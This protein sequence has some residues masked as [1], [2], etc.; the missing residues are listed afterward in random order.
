MFAE[1]VGLVRG[2]AVEHL[3]RSRK[4]ALALVGQCGVALVLGQQCAVEHRGQYRPLDFGHSPEA[5]LPSTRLVF[6]PLGVEGVGAVFLREIEVDRH[7]LPQDDPVV[8]DGRDVPVRV[9]LEVV[10]GAGLALAHVDRDVLVF[11]PQLLRHPQDTEGARTRDA[12]DFERHDPSSAARRNSHERP[13]QGNRLRIVPGVRRYAALG[14]GSCGLTC[15]AGFGCSAA[16][17]CAGSAVWPGSGVASGSGRTGAETAPLATRASRW[18][19]VVTVMPPKVVSVFWTA[20]E[21]GSGLKAATTLSRA[22][23]SRSLP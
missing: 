17:T 22:V 16:L 14:R 20:C 2:G 12:V 8:V 11:D 6:E 19:S 15:S 10:G 7:R 13:D 18:V 4:V 5:P 23:N 1:Q 9:D 3:E 21:A